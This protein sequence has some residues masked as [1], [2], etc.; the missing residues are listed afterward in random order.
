MRSS[1]TEQHKLASGSAWRPS[2]FHSQLVESPDLHST[3]YHEVATQILCAGLHFILFCCA[4]VNPLSIMF[5]KSIIVIIELYSVF[6]LKCFQMLKFLPT[7][8]W[9]TS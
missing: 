5:A 9:P 3:A 8:L 2:V 1:A 4:N 6:D 7:K